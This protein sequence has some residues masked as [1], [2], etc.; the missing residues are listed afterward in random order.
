VNGESSTRCEVEAGELSLRAA[1]GRNKV[2][3][4]GCVVIRDAQ[5]SNGASIGRPRRAQ[6]VAGARGEPHRCTAAYLLQVNAKIAFVSAVPTECDLISVRRQGWVELTAGLGGQRN[7]LDHRFGA[8]AGRHDGPSSEPGQG[9]R[10]ASSRDPKP[11]SAL[12][13]GCEAGRI[14]RSLRNQRR[15]PIPSLGHGFD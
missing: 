11:A 9:N 14:S 15:K 8:V 7:T 2:D 5:E 10:S 4:N 6:I 13:A 3:S 1:Q 12:T